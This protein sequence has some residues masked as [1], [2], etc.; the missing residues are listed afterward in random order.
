MRYVASEPRRPG[1]VDKTE[2][3]RVI[4]L[5]NVPELDAQQAGLQTISIGDVSIGPITV[6]TLVANAVGVNFSS[7]PAVLNNVV[8]TL[9]LQLAATWNIHIPMPWPIP[10]V[11]ISGSQSLGSATFGPFGVGDVLIP[12]LAGVSLNIPT[13]TVANTSATVAPLSN[14]QLTSV[15]ADT[16]KAQ[17]TQLPSA[18]FSLAGLLLGS[19]DGANITVPAAAIG[20]ASVGHVSGPPISVPA[21]A[22]GPVSAPSVT[23][24]SA[25]TVGG[26]NVQIDLS[27]FHI[28]TTGDIAIG[29]DITPTAQ[30]HVDGL[31]ISN[32]QA[33]ASVGQ[34]VA[35]NVVVP[36]DAHNLTLANL[37]INNIAIPSFAIA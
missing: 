10:D 30:T 31:S 13:L 14:L 20:S 4:M 3:Q 15:A 6:A 5:V 21:L 8:V 23:F 33:S 22:L 27:T 2:M 11:N 19:V 1:T 37:G 28:G 25:Q 24:P 16:I 17:N 29:F 34:L 9:T 32:G 12:S 7:G 26:L 36:Y 18:G 35:H